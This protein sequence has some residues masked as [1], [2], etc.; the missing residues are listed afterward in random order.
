[1]TPAEIQRR[2]QEKFAAAISDF[3]EPNAG[4][5]CIGVAPDKLHA[6]CLLLRSD[7]QFDFDFLKIVSALDLGDRYAS[8]YHL[9][10]YRHGHSLT[11]KTE[12]ARENPQ[13]ESVSDIWPAA[14]WHEREAFDMMGIVYSGHPEL[15]RI[16]LPLDWDGH[17][18]RKDYKEP[19]SYHGI[20]ND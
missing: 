2:L 20:R 10:S 6:V 14:N 3:A 19:Q 18:L 9:Y 16:L 8:V 15:K 13:V 1:M 12:L 5:P 11:L 4:D 7:P 17:P